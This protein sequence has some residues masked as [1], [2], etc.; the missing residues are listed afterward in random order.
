[1]MD[2][3]HPGGDDDF[4]VI[5]KCSDIQLIFAGHSSFTVCLLFLAFPKCLTGNESPGDL[6]FAL[7]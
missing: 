3:W 1:M 2:V 5:H 4:H 7:C 6:V